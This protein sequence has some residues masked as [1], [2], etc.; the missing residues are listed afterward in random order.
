MKIA[1]LC[2]SL[3][4]V[5]SVQFLAQSGTL[6]AIGIPTVEHEATA[7]LRDLAA[8]LHVPLTVF[9]KD[10][11]AIE[12]EIWFRNSGADALLVYTFPYLLKGELL[13]LPALGC[14]NF[15]FGLL[16]QYR[17]SDAIFWEIRNREPFGA[18]T[19]HR[20]EA[21]LDT[22]PVLIQEMVSIRPVDTYGSHMENLGMVGV[23]CTHETLSHLQQGL[24]HIE[25]SPQDESIARVWPKP[26]QQDV[27]IDWN[28]MSAEMIAALVRACNP[29][30][31]GAYTFLGQQA[32]RITVA[33]VSTQSAEGQAPGTLIGDTASEI[34]VACANDDSLQ[35]DV[36]FLDAGFFG[37][38]DFQALGIHAG[39]RFSAPMI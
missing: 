23:K 16:P 32:L 21:S 6:A 3:M 4:G 20:M 36:I 13:A 33:R 31:K 12:A 29:W 25:W 10:S 26:G 5:P 8:F 28:S 19:V 37:S 17:G 24:E 38:R 7:T 14:L 2:N 39:M 27:L 9:E 30:N 35:V 22:G 15:H 1:V 18:V 11:F 34:R